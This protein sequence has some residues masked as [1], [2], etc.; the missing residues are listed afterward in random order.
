[1]PP[2][3]LGTCHSERAP[4]SA[5][6]GIWP[7]YN[8]AAATHHYASLQYRGEVALP[9]LPTIQSRGSIYRPSP[10]LRAS[11]VPPPSHSVFQPNNTSC[12]LELSPY[13]LI[14]PQSKNLVGLYPRLVVHAKTPFIEFPLPLWERIKVRGKPW[15]HN[16]LSL[17]PAM[18]RIILFPPSAWEV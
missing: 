6:R 11:N 18:L 1:M 16:A 5:R 3:T 9:P 15:R 4:Y 7:H 14:N 10:S 13:V 2:P 17:P 8:P 12:H